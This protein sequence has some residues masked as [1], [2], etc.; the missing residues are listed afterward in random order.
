MSSFTWPPRSLGGTVTSLSVV[1]ANGFAGSVATATTTPAITLTTTITGIL[2]G[3][4]TA[5]IAATT[6]NLTAAGTDGI[7][8]TTGTGAVLGSGTSIAQQVSDA[9]HNGY[10]SSANWV[11]F[12]AKVGTST[13]DVLTNKTISGASNTLSNIADGS[14][15]TSYLKADG[16]RTLTANW[17]ADGF[18]GTFNSVV[19]G[20]SANTISALS[21]IV[22]TGTLTLPTATDTIVGRQTTDTLTNKTIS[23]A[24]NTLSSIADGSLTT[25][26]IKA[27][28]TRALTA[29]WAA[30]AFSAT[31]NSVVVGSAA[32]TIS[33]LSTIVNTGTIT[34]PTATD[35]LVARATT[36][37]LTNKTIS[38]ASNTLSS[39]GDGSLSTSYLKAD[40]SRAL[41]GAWTAGA[42]NHTIGSASAG[43]ARLT[44]ID[45]SNTP[46]AGST[47]SV[48]NLATSAMFLNGSA[49]GTVTAGESTTDSMMRIRKDGTS[50][51]SINAAGTLNASGADYAE[52]MVKSDPKAIIKAGDVCGINEQGQLTTKYSESIHFMVKSTNPSY[53][54]GDSW[55]SKEESEFESK[56]KFLEALEAA[57][58]LVDRIAFCGK[59]PCNMP[60]K[61]VMPGDFLV[62]VEGKSDSIDLQM[63]MQE[64]IT[65]EQFIKSVGKVIKI[66][67]DK[68]VQLLVGV[69]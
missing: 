35:T 59:V 10:L 63:I 14:L 31:H 27:D 33:A 44:V 65:L 29:N 30:G 46:T 36:D 67:D 2:Q 61:G 53:V 17:N 54:G 48:Q 38:G 24:S 3:N 37:T 42:F 8:I 26:Y 40:G 22:N 39:I 7:A 51:R 19:V 52:Y 16:S 57:R 60:S 50:N 18:S 68:S 45:A 23:G 55:F 56:D 21:T 64:E 13:T 20:S 32:N 12:N 4:G 28:G 6:G 1:T 69:K 15:S 58:A 11:T 34:L 49:A 43:S 66:I 47:F 5:I 41:T 9:T 25:P 62:P